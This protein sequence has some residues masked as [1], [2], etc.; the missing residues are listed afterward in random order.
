M[1]LKAKLWL[2]AESLIILCSSCNRIYATGEE[3]RWSFR[4][5][6]LSSKR[7]FY[8]S[9]ALGDSISSEFFPTSYN[10]CDIVH[11]R[12]SLKS[13]KS[14]IEINSISALELRKY[15][16]WRSHIWGHSMSLICEIGGVVV[17]TVVVVDASSQFQS[18]AYRPAAAISKL[19]VQ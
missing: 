2:V 4:I 5:I 1:A 7:Y 9:S 3:S 18:E 10:T 19:T 15:R 11:T 13:V 16:H 12:G 6:E 17:V 14:G 8:S